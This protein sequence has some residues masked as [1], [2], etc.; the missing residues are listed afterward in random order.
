MNTLPYTRILLITYDNPLTRNTGDS[1][2]TANIID[3]LSRI[4]EAI[5]IIYYDSNT[6]LPVIP[7]NNNLFAKKFCIPF[8][9]KTIFPFIFSLKPSV[10]VNRQSKEYEEAINIALNSE[11][12]D[13]VLINHFKM[14]FTIP[15]VKSLIKNNTRIVYI[16]HNVE[17]L[18]NKNIARNSPLLKKIIYSIEA[19]KTLPRE[20]LCIQLSDAVTAISEHDAEAFQAIYGLEQVLLLRPVLDFEE[21][22]INS[23]RPWNQAIVAGSFIWPPKL[24]NLKLLLG[25]NNFNKLHAAGIKVFV[26]GRADYQVV[27]EINSTH[28]NVLMTGQVPTLLPYYAQVRIAMVPE[29]LGGG[30]KLKVAEAALNKSLMIAIKG[31]IT[32]CA[33]IPGVHFIECST[34]E[35]MID[36]LIDLQRP[37]R[38]AS[39]LEMI[40][41]AHH[42][43]LSMHTLSAITD[44][45]RTL[46]PSLKQK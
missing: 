36:T 26:V 11:N 32:K 22:D 38:H 18:L 41:R 14:G 42:L 20:N 15:L 12:Y 9:S 46:L 17:F 43:A 37:D 35:D 28:L 33:F 10:F 25:A 39:A 4:T 29:R 34:Y 44:A 19:I 23:Q 31:A 6:E 24:T 30:F 2:Y 27:Q 5:D 21:H 1:I 16:S 7:D 40:E 3:A 45:F 13:L 8:K